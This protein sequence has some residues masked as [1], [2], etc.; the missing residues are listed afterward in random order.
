LSEILIYFVKNNVDENMSNALLEILTA[1][2]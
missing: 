2:E 1:L